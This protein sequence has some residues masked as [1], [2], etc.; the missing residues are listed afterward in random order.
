LNTTRRRK[1]APSYE[2][3]LRIKGWFCRPHEVNMPSW[4]Q[5][6]YGEGKTFTQWLD[7]RPRGS[8]KTVGTREWALKCWGF[9]EQSWQAR[10]AKVGAEEPPMS[11]YVD[12]F[13]E[14]GSVPF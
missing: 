10:L 5:Q 12:R 1:S 9:T 14:D 2:S 11:A 3:S 7:E 13:V 6:R 4:Q 8:D